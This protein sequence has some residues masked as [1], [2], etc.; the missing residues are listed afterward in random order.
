VIEA[1]DAAV[2]QHGIPEITNSAQGSLFTC[3]SWVN[4]LPELGIT[5]SM[6][7]RGR[8]TDNIYIE[9]FWRTLKQDYAY[10]H[11]AEN[12]ITLWKESNGSLTITTERKPSR[13]LEDI[14]R[15]HC[16]D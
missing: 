8:A 1:L 11:P 12:G 9:R 3:P 14:R 15:K 16:I 7:G 6:N 2:L 4:K 10:S 13:V 5:I